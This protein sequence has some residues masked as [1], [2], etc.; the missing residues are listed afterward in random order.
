[1]GDQLDLSAGDHPIPLAEKKRS[2]FLLLLAAGGKR[3]G[4]NRQEAD[5]QGLGSLCE[6][7]RRRIG[8]DECAG[9]EHRTP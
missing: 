3:P 2:A 4:K 5:F 6:E 9:L 7:P 8:A 1:L